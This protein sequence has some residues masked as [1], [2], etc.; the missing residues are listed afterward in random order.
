MEGP[1]FSLV[2]DPWIPCIMS[3]ERKELGLGEV[4]SR[5]SEITE[6]F[7]P[8]PLITLTLHRLLLAIL[9]RNLGPGSLAKWKHLF[10]AGTFDGQPLER[11][12]DELGHRFFLFHPDFPF[13]QDAS[14]VGEKER[15]PIAKLARELSSI[16]GTTLFDHSFDDARAAVQPGHAARLV[17]V[18]QSYAIPDGRGYQTS[19]LTHGVSVVV[20]G[21]NLFETLMFN[22]VIYNSE[23]PIA[24]DLGE[25]RPCW[26][27]DSQTR[28]TAIPRG[29]VDYLTWPHRRILL[30]HCHGELTHTYFKS[31]PPISKEWTQL[32]RDP[33]LYYTQSPERGYEAIGISEERALWR[34][35]HSMMS[36]VKRRNGVEPGFINLIA[37]L[38]IGEK[39]LSAF[40]AVAD[41]NAIE[42]WRHERL[43]LPPIY[44]KEEGPGEALRSALQ[45]AEK[46]DGI[47]GS[48]L[49]RMAREIG[50]GKRDRLRESLPAQAR[51]IYWSSLEVPFRRLLVA[52]P[53]DE[54]VLDGI[55]QFGVQKELPNWAT[56]V[57]RTAEEAFDS[58]CGMLGT[59]GRAF[60]AVT[61]ARDTLMKK[62]GGLMKPYLISGK[63]GA[64]D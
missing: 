34:E 20:R 49:R 56:F 5:A 38:G 58:A 42:L 27:Y 22:L 60:K 24:S 46:V 8:S 2:D 15:V 33:M 4:L 1:S 21:T 12:F 19:P 16:G 63:D 53:E 35:S 51:R 52:L 30:V 13:L 57:R 25:D 45:L 39:E 31:G 29:Y 64:N 62:I 36:L 28:T 40:G 11:Y 14:L 55:K 48:E 7:D 50:V 61:I 6:V 37:R 43:P 54:S 47:L 9:H 26:E 32:N 10:A 44:L 41:N 17:L 23:R 3:G 59:S 18:F